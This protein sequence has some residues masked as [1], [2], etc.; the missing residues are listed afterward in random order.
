MLTTCLG[1]PIKAVTHE[2][3]NSQSEQVTFSE[4]GPHEQSEPFEPGEGDCFGIPLLMEENKGPDLNERAAE[5][6]ASYREVRLSDDLSR[7]IFAPLV[8]DFKRRSLSETQKLA[9]LRNPQ[10]FP[11]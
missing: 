5:F 4:I 10:C 6:L 7:V 3:E 9:E 1:C 8:E 2:P 11:I